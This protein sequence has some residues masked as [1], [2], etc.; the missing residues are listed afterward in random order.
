[1]HI[2]STA[3]SADGA[4]LKEVASNGLSFVKLTLEH[5]FQII[6]I[7]ERSKLT[8]LIIQLFPDLNPH[9]NSARFLPSSTIPQN[10]ED[11]VYQSG[12][13]PAYQE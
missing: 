11:I 9:L 7:T 13:L 5:D 4:M 12:A 10:D 3:K 8:R 2:G 1:M 6:N